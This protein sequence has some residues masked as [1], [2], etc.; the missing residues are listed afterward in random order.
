MPSKNINFR[1]PVDRFHSSHQIHSSLLLRTS[2]GIFSDITK[3]RNSK[4]LDEKGQL[5][6]EDAEFEIRQGSVA[7]ENNTIRVKRVSLFVLKSPLLPFHCLEVDVQA[8]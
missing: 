6:D 4:E 5:I 1:D 2:N 8:T 3:F 7:T